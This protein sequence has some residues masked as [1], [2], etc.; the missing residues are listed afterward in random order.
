MMLRR[1]SVLSPCKITP[2]A[3]DTKSAKALRGLA[4]LW[5][6]GAPLAW[7]DVTHQ[8]PVGSPGNLSLFGWDDSM[9]SIG[10]LAVVTGALVLTSACSDGGGTTPPDNQRP[11]ANFTEVCTQLSCVFTD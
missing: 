11:E 5:R 1:V 4:R 2:C 6:T 10:M 9:R 3:G 7:C 8:T